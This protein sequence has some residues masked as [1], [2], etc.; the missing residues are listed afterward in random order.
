MATHKTLY[1]VYRSMMKSCY[2]ENCIL[3]HSFGGKGIEVCPEWHNRDTFYE[4]CKTNEWKAGMKVSRLDKEKDFCPE[5]CFLEMQ[6]CKKAQRIKPKDLVYAAFG[7]RITKHPIYHIYNG[8]KQRCYNP[9]NREY[10]LY[11]ARGIT[12]AKDWL[13]K[14]GA[15]K[16][17]IWS[18]ENGWEEGL[19]IDRMNNDLGYSPDN[20]RWTDDTTQAK[21]RRNVILH[22]YNGKMLNL[23]EISEEAKVSRY[24]LNDF[25]NKQKLTT[26]DAIAKIKKADAEKEEKARRKKAERLAREI[27]ERKEKERIRAER[28]ENNRNARALRREEMRLLERERCRNEM[29]FSNGKPNYS[30]IARKYGV[31]QYY[32]NM[33]RDNGMSV[34]DIIAKLEADAPK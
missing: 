27:A 28:K 20:C 26:Y 8:M 5:N 13:G 25:V 11:G 3:Y 7:D 10:R 14:Y 31:T 16:F 22:E 19:T 1:D 6:K 2:D 30:A 17:I 9:D 33:M 24:R 34:Q 29:C 15:I 12:I 4:W 21:N 23:T 32:I 18:L